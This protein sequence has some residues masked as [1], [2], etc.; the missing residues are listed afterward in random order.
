MIG[1][2]CVLV[3]SALLA[4]CAAE[5]ILIAQSEEASVPDAS[6]D[7]EVPAE[8]AVEAGRAE[9]GQVSD[10][11]VGPS[12]PDAGPIAPVPCFNDQ[13]C[14]SARWYCAKQACDDPQFLQPGICMRRSRA[15]QCG[16]DF[17][18]VCGCDGVT[19]FN[20]CL[21]QAQGVNKLASSECGSRAR[22]GP[23]VRTCPVYASCALLIDS[24]DGP[25]PDGR[26]WA[27]PPDCSGSRGP[28]EQ[29]QRC[30]PRA[31]A[32]RECVGLCDAIREQVPY[33][34]SSTCIHKPPTFP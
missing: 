5:E 9:A 29:F 3:W 21:R 12:R 24:C 27:V 8:A 28:D 19:Y 13:G 20:D 18:P 33:I 23:N 30:S 10:A 7:A 16:G 1:G 15:D 6:L 4:G 17:F 26:C 2:R 25:L 31:G 11:F 34:W 22:C 14:P 32:E